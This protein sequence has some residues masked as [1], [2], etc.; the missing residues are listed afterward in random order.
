[1]DDS[2]E[3]VGKLVLTDVKG[4]GSFYTST[5]DNV[6]RIWV[7]LKSEVMWWVMNG[8]KSFEIVDSTSCGRSIWTLGIT[9]QTP[10]FLDWCAHSID[11]RVITSTYSWLNLAVTSTS[12][13]QSDLVC[14]PSILIILAI[15]KGHNGGDRVRS[16]NQVG[17]YSYCEVLA[18]VHLSKNPCVSVLGRC[19]WSNFL[20]ASLDAEF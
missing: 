6:H 16:I 10:P 1:M 17:P 2:I 8:I 9:Y 5:K 12:H 15:R 11:Y 13:L 3:V 20:K 19:N 7:V 18:K 4:R 14:N